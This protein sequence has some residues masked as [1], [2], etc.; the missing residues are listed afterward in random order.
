MLSCL[1]LLS[2]GRS[3]GIDWF[4]PTLA[5]G[6]LTCS[7]SYIMDQK[8]TRKENPFP[9]HSGWA[10]HQPYPYLPIYLWLEISGELLQFCF[11]RLEA[12]RGVCLVPLPGQW[13][14]ALLKTRAEALKRLIPQT[15]IFFLLFF[16]T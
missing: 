12:V 3:L 5:P 14:R 2:Y 16:V 6:S 15:P 13:P 9:F 8:R 4:G 10:A 1:F 7:S 11:M